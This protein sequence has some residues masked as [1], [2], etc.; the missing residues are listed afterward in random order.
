M[1]EIVETVSQGNEAKLRRRI[2]LRNSNTAIP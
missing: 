1:Y 2:L